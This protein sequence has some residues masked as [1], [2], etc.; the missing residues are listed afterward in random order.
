MSIR[1]VFSQMFVG[2]TTGWDGLRFIHLGRICLILWAER[3]T[4]DRYPFFRR[5]YVYPNREG[6]KNSG[7]YTSSLFLPFL[8]LA[9]VGPLRH[10]SFAPLARVPVPAAIT[11]W[12][13]LATLE[14]FSIDPRRFFPLR[15]CCYLSLSPL[16]RHHVSRLGDLWI[17]TRVLYTSRFFLQAPTSGQDLHGRANRLRSFMM[18]VTTGDLIPPKR[19]GSICNA[20]SGWL[21]ISLFIMITNIF[22]LSKFTL[23]FSCFF[24]SLKFFILFYF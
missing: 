1:S 12:R 11:G 17:G 15:C 5:L 10:L 8:P 16:Y 20:S 21:G 14:R 23:D 22:S 6:Y 24:S 13:Y 4:P 2:M 9:D 19:N 18:L 3:D 7:F